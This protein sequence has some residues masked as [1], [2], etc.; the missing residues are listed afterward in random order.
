MTALQ[1]SLRI[2]VG[3]SDRS[4]ASRVSTDLNRPRAL[5]GLLPASGAADGPGTSFV[6]G[7]A[8][9]TSIGVVEPQ[10]IKKLMEPASASIVSQWSTWRLPA[11]AGRV[12]E[13]PFHAPEVDLETM[14]LSEEDRHRLRS[15]CLDDYAY[16]RAALER[17]VGKAA[18]SYV[19]GD[20]G[21]DGVLMTLVKDLDR[22]YLDLYEAYASILVADG[23]PRLPVDAGQLKNWG[24]SH[25][26]VLQLREHCIRWCEIPRRVAAS[27]SSLN[28]SLTP[29]QNE[30]AQRFIDALRQGDEAA[31]V[32]M[33]TGATSFAAAL[34][35]FS[36]LLREYRPSMAVMRQLL[37][38]LKEYAHLEAIDERRFYIERVARM[39]PSP[40]VEPLDALYMELRYRIG[41]DSGDGRQQSG[42]VGYNP[43]A[44]L[45]TVRG[46]Y[47]NEDP[48]AVFRT[49]MF[50][51]YKSNTLANEIMRDP[52]LVARINEHLDLNGKGWRLNTPLIE[53]LRQRNADGPLFEYGRF[54]AENDN[55]GLR[56]L[57]RDAEIERLG[58][59]YPNRTYAQSYAAADSPRGHAERYATRLTTAELRA[60]GFDV[61][62]AP[63]RP[64]TLSSPGRTM[65]A[66][67]TPDSYRARTETLPWTPGAHVFEV[68]SPQHPYV[69]AA[70]A[71]RAPLLSGISGTEDQST[72]M[73]GI[74]GRHRWEDRLQ[75]RL[76]LIAWMVP[77]DDHSLLEILVASETFGLPCTFDVAPHECVY[78]L[79]SEFSERVL[80]A[81]R[82]L[83]F[84]LPAHY[85]TAEHARRRARDLC[86]GCQP[87]ATRRAGEI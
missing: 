41:G 20:D 36:R 3:V 38:R 63:L 24:Y 80:K 59:E 27:L 87:F 48:L 79:D 42:S 49:R 39:R 78:P 11:Q 17:A 84:E 69:A 29:S 5:G 35:V 51:V 56:R 83:G 74:V 55:G 44:I 65:H 64:D 43:L 62:R 40:Y 45:S 10:R 75:M 12:P 16:A 57:L 76:A 47:D 22:R 73:A 53:T 4:D 52:T 21:T 31:C 81:Q 15:A 61:C 9:N 34:P 68:L 66:T 30:E 19:C 18:Q 82:E 71:L 33:A 28:P 58:R 7:S 46:K 26:E 6:A 37:W 77:A 60:H 23:E 13:F 50:F 54:A 70:S 1:P 25:R 32:A 8:A 67:E 72:V 2:G 85:L 14:A 86:I